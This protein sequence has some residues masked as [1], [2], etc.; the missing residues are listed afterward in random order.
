MPPSPRRLSK[1]EIQ[2]A[3]VKMI[4]ERDFQLVT[5]D[6][7]IDDVR[8]IMRKM[9]YYLHSAD[10]TAYSTAM[11]ELNIDAMALRKRKP[12]KRKKN[13]NKKSRRYK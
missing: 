6:Y 12:T 9:Q 4:H 7:H 10:D 2:R 8:E 3:A 5:D 13:K 11:R 1:E